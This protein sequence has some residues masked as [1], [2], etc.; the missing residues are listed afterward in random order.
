MRNEYVEI[1][2]LVCNG[3]PVIAGTRIPVT[4][5]LGC[6]EDGLALDDILRKYPEL[7]R[8]QLVGALRFCRVLVTHTE[9]EPALG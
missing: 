1:T 7:R 4:L 6:L 5:I 3:Q 8:D 9:M 2:P